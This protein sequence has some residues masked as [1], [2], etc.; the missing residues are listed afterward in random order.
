MGRRNYPSIE[1]N[2]YTPVV[3]RSPN[4]QL[5]KTNNNNLYNI[6]S[7]KVHINNLTSNRSLNYSNNVSKL[8]VSGNSNNANVN[9]N[10]NSN[11]SRNYR[12]LTNIISTINN[13]VGN[14]SFIN[15]NNEHR[16]HSNS[17]IINT[18]IL[19]N[20]SFTGQQLR[21][22]RSK[23]FINSTRTYYSFLKD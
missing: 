2:H 7:N 12:R 1:K 8:N 15:N 3:S 14:N 10:L 19:H 5:T 9:C 4:I 21:Q 18:P 11:T 22:D 20:K 6:C 16:V 23:S 13:D 17:Y